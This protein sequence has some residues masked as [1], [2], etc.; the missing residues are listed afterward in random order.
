V[1]GT[2]VGGN[3]PSFSVSLYPNPAN[4]QTYLQYTLPAATTMQVEVWNALGQKLSTPVTNQ[5]QVAGNYVIPIRMEAAGNYY[6][7]VTADGKPMWF[8]VENVK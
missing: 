4:S 7:K 1:L 6:V 3:A 5:S 8:K 2:G